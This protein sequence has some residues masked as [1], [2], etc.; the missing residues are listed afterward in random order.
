[1]RAR[2]RGRRHRGCLRRRPLASGGS[3]GS[4][5]TRNAITG[6][7]SLM[8]RRTVS[9][10]SR[11]L[12]NAEIEQT[13]REVRGLALVKGVL[14]K[15]GVSRAEPVAQGKELGGSRQGRAE[16]IGSRGLEPGSDRLGE[17]A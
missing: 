6:G 5:G 2:T 15:R 13:L 16:L 12:L 8:L 3:R 10:S 9:Q 7:G 14:K 1:D 11:A 17:A 4:A